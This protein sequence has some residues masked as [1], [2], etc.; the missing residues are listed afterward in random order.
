MPEGLSLNLKI[1]DKENWANGIV[2]FKQ[3]LDLSKY[4]SIV[5]WAKAPKA[6]TRVWMG[7]RTDELQA[8]TDVLPEGGFPKGEIVELVIPL[9]RFFFQATD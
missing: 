7:L 5:L 6:G 1:T 3:P 9:S 8:R 4:N 2:H